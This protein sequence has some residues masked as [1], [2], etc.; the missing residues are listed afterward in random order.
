M[1]NQ[2]ITHLANNT[3]TNNAVNFFKLLSSL[4]NIVCALN[5]KY[6]N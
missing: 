6:I 5:E 1:S 3:N 2:T 4:T